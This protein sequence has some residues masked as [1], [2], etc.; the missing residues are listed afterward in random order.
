MLLHKWSQYQREGEVE[1][2]IFCI[3]IV[4]YHHVLFVLE[5]DS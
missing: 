3:N 5:I 1:M 4:E 2:D